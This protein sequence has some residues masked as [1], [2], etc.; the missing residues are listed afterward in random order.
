MLVESFLSVERLVM[1]LTIP[2][3][4]TVGI[5]MFSE[6]SREYLAPLLH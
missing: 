1:L 5:N 4:Q 3:H 2:S 6:I